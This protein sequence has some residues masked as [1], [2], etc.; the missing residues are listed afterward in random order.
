MSTPVHPEDVTEE[1]RL[2]EA[3]AWRAYLTEND[4]ATSDSFEGWL[5]ADPRNEA[6]WRQVQG[7]WNFFGEHANAP[8]LLELRRTALQEAQEAG[9]KRWQPGRRVGRYAAVAAGLLAMVG[10]L[11]AWMARQPDV[12]RTEAGERRMIRLPDGSQIALDSRSEVRVRY[13][14]L[15]RE[16]TLTTGQA[17]FDV[18]HDASRPF[19]VI[20]GGQRV[21]ATGT[22]FNVDLLDERVVVTL[23]E[24]RVTV[25][26]SVPGAS[27]DHEV[28]LVPG[29][30][31]IVSPEAPPEVVPASLE[32]TTAWQNGR[33]VFENEPL[34]EVVLRLNRYSTRA[35]RIGDPRAGELRISGVFK[36]GD[37][38][39]FIATITAYLPVTAE[40]VEGDV[41]EL[42]HRERH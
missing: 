38:P 16:L 7:P 27:A 41:V 22:A 1:R 5:A 28:Q 42:R 13:T 40:D 4:L 8:E 23:L 11:F 34:S 30:Q 14:D 9:R 3:A 12:Y 37:V 39:G 32:R 15:A 31:L 35:L 26:P 25:A 36:T 17:R 24:G 2:V 20:A 18:V 19:S 6:A 33:V 21:V 29:E 10:A